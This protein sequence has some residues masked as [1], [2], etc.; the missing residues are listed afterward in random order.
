MTGAARC[1]WQPAAGLTNHLSIKNFCL[2][3]RCYP[4][5]NGR[6]RLLPSIHPK[7]LQLLTNPPEEKQVACLALQRPQPFRQ[8]AG[9]TLSLNVLVAASRQIDASRED[10][11]DLARRNTVPDYF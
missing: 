5:T 7:E 1:W 9:T 2:H 11:F 8:A 3:N 10:W 6:D 4:R